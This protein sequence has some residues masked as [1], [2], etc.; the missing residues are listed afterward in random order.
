MEAF[1]EPH[2]QG[3]LIEQLYREALLLADESRSYFEDERNVER[4][5]LSPLGRV[6]YSCEA[7][8]VTTRLLHSIAWLLTHRAVLA[9]ELSR[10]DALDPSR[11]LGTAPVS[12][13]DVLAMLPV[14]ALALVRASQELHRRVA[15]L[16]AAQADSAPLRSPVHAMR[17]RLATAF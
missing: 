3:R 12:G 6:A 11:R 2:V 14:A 4:D 9:G 10:R 7:M 15:R 5:R 8:K 16:D 1:A 13:P 17:D